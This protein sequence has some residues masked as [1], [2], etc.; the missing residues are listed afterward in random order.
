MILLIAAGIGF[1]LALPKYNDLEE[2]KMKVAEK[3]A[4]IE[5][6][7][8]YFAELSRAA[9]ELSQHE[10]N[11]EKVESAFPQTMDAPAMMDFIQTAAM[12]SGLIAKDVSFDGGGVSVAAEKAGDGTD[13]VSARQAFKL[14]A[15]AVEGEF[16]G[17]YSNF[18]DFLRRLEFSSRLI[19]TESVEIGK[20]MDSEETYG[21]KTD[22]GGAGDIKDNEEDEINPMLDFKVKLVINYYKK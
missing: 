7:Q 21:K 18:K 12:Q 20:S 10:A 4:E 14:N 9:I 11:L 13:T 2:T 16:I 6:R 1:F 19:N 8:E 15:Y 3:N 17:N 22:S 5:N